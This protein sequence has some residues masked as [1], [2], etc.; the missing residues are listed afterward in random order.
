MA[1]STSCLKRCANA[2]SASSDETPR[3]GYGAA[4]RYT[5]PG[6]GPNPCLYGTTF[7]V[8]AIVRLVRPW[9]A[10]SNTIT[11]GR[12]VAVLAIFTAFSTASAPEFT[13]SDFVSTPGCG[14]R[15]VEEP[16]DLDVRLVHPD[17]EALVEIAVDLLVDRSGREAVAGVLASEPAGE[18]DVL[19]T[20]D[21]PDPCAFRAGDDEWRSGDTA[22]D[23]A[24]A[25]SEN[26][27]AF[28]CLFDAR[29]HSQ[30]SFH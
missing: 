28:D 5:S 12:P 7:A 11:A 18:V 29:R 21:V 1:G 13:S 19:A 23:V 25:V 22:R 24:C 20:V 6:N 10:W 27:P 2:S 17:H 26:P 30:S 16:A 15:L 14:Q 4:D 3:Y 8:I 9:N